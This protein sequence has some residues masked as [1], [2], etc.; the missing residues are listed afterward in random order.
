MAFLGDEDY[1]YHYKTAMK[2]AANAEGSENGIKCRLRQR[3]Q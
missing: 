1:G 2:D 3:T